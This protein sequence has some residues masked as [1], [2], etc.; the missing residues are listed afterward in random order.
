MK[1]A[2]I[3]ITIIPL[4]VM[5]TQAQFTK[6]Q[7]TQTAPVKK[8]PPTVVN[9]T[10]VLIGTVIQPPA[11]GNFTNPSN[12]FTMPDGK[13]VT[14]TMRQGTQNLPN[15]FGGVVK[16]DVAGSSKDDNGALICN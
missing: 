15:N 14:M 2:I 3:L 8:S 9:N 11:T 12:T 13:R 5:T 10:P 16:E 6:I 4:M 1:N 7:K